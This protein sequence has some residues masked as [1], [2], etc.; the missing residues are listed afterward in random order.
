MI[1][2]GEGQDGA[3]QDAGEEEGQA[4]A[5]GVEGHQATTPTEVGVRCDTAAVDERIIVSISRS[6]TNIYVI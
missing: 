6:P 1:E 3:E 4:R 2:T 5:G